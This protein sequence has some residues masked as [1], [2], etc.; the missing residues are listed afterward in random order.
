MVLVLVVML[1]FGDLSGA[2]GT[3]SGPRGLVYDS[4]IGYW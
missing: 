4:Y 2:P 1:D 3:M